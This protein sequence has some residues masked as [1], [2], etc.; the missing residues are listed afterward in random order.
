M[1]RNNK[2]RARTKLC[3]FYIYTIARRTLV[4]F[5]QAALE[6]VLEPG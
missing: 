3:I 6:G 4:L 5:V 2:R 1:S